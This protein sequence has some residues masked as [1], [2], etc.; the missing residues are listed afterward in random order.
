MCGSVH[1]GWEHSAA[2]H[3]TTLATENV[4]MVLYIVWLA[5]GVV[6]GAAKVVFA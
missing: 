2:L 1:E 5:D 6:V 3:A 4:L